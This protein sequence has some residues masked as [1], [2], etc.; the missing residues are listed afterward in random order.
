MSASYLRQGIDFLG[1]LSTQLQELQG[2]ATLVNELVQNAD[3]APGV[4][5]VCFDVRNDALEIS[6]DGSF[7]EQDFDRMRNIAGG[8]KRQETDTTGAFGIG[9]LAVYQVTDH[10]E[11]F[12][13][14]RHWVFHPEAA[15]DKRIVQEE[16]IADHG[17]TRFRLPWATDPQ[18]EVRRKLS[19]PPV[20]AK[21]IERL[22]EQ[23]DSLLPQAILFLRKVS[24]IQLCRNGVPVRVV[25][26]EVDG[27]QV[28]VQDGTKTR[29]WYRLEGDFYGRANELR[30]QYEGYI[31]PKRKATV[32]LA[33][34]QD[35]D[36]EQG[37]L[38]AYLPTQDSSNLS[39]HINADFF[40]TR[41]RKHIILGHNYHYQDE[42]NRA[43][44][45]AAAQKLATILPEL[46]KL[47]G[48]Q[49]FWRSL[50][51]AEES[52]RLAETGTID[53]VFGE[54]WN[55]MQP[56]LR[57]IPNVYTSDKRW[58]VPG[59]VF[60]LE[61]EEEHEAIP[62]LEASGLALVH[63]E[64]R[65]FHNLLMNKAVGV[66]RLTARDV[67]HA[68]C[69][70]GLCKAMDLSEAPSWIQS[71]HSR[72][73]LSREIGV[74]LRRRMSEAD[75]DQ[76]LVQI[77][78]CALG[79]GADGRLYPLADIRKASEE[80]KTLFQGATAQIVFL[81]PNNPE[82]LQELI[83]EFDPESALTALEQTPPETL[84][85]NWKSGQWRPAVLLGWF[86]QREASLSEKQK[87]RLAD[88]PIY[89]CGDCLRPLSGLWLPGGFS[90][91]LNLAEL[92]EVDSLPGLYDFLRK[93]GA[94]ELT[95]S[96][97]VKEHVPAVFD[98]HPRITDEARRALVFELAKHIGQIKDDEEARARLAECDFV[99]CD[100]GTFRKAPQVYLRNTTILDVL[101]ESVPT[102]TLPVDN[103]EAVRDLLLWLGVADSP[104][105]LDVLTRIQALVESA[106]VPDRREAIR[107]AFR[108]LGTVWK[109]RTE[110]WDQNVS[111]LKSLAWLPVENDTTSW[112]KPRDVFAVFQRYLCE[113]QARFLDI[114]YGDQQAASEFV[115]WLGVRETPDPAMVVAH[116]LAC[117]SSGAQVNRAVYRFLADSADDHV[118]ELLKG[119]PC[120]LLSTGSYAR[121][122]QVYWREHPFGTYRHQLQ[123]ELREYTKLFERLG[124][125]EGPQWQDA[126]QVLQ[127][128]SARFGPANTV[129][130]DESDK[131]AWEC[132]KLLDNALEQELTDLS[133][134]KNRLG[135]NKVVPDSRR[136]LM[137][138][139]RLFFDDR[140][141][142]KEKFPD[143]LQQHIVPLYQEAWRALE[144]AGVRPLS[145]VVRTDLIEC[146]NAR[147][148]E[149][150]I[151]LLAERK[152]LITRVVEP[153]Q[154]GQ[155][156]ATLA[157]NL[158][159][160]KFLRVDKLEV[161]YVFDGFGQPIPTSPES[162]RAHYEPP[163]NTLYFAEA[164]GVPWTPIAREL[165]YTLCRG[166]K[167]GHV[168]LA[169]KEILSAPSIDDASATLDELGFAPLKELGEKTLPPKPAVNLADAARVGETSTTPETPREASNA[170]FGEGA[171]TPTAPLAD[172][173]EAKN[174]SPTRKTE[175]PVATASKSKSRLRTYVAPE[176]AT[177]S[178]E[179]P[180]KTRKR[181]QVSK[182]G[183]MKVVEAERRAGRVPTEMPWTHRGY[184]IVSRNST[185][186]IERYIE[187]KALTGT[188]ADSPGV[189]LTKDE[190]EEAREKGGM[191]WLYVVERACGE[192]SCIIRIQDP[193]RK[194]GTFFYD[195]GWR[196]LAESAG[197]GDSH[198]ED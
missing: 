179:D 124:V 155:N 74:L 14:G 176:D 197:D 172:V 159:E 60:F 121:P 12:S 41:D 84:Q 130:D 99:E 114:P 98:K 110:L 156:G 154:V 40:P 85:A 93:L 77:R 55:L 111:E 185:E 31:E 82:D 5:M 88:L 50:G 63:P 92:V 13:S 24:R 181:Q 126:L 147:A 29:L 146:H 178:S 44:L 170:I 71:Q 145:K 140:P 182:A 115:K 163:S 6:N 39:F 36:S 139:E 102:A 61:S 16:G 133:T 3:D 51:R 134:L 68:L 174:G 188:W 168:A 57:E 95:F 153:I 30:S 76:A 122:H 118:L 25:Q 4:T 73:I 175:R 23:L 152:L 86:E 157:D 132:W 113:T 96:A 180:E 131:V 167:S 66:R 2:T 65:P 123:P 148:A 106:P 72:E 120:L 87:K 49:G 43:A 190:F 67:A 28:L 149:D 136:V 22:P 8:G 107:R 108:F 141:G 109:A 105:S 1:F 53:P 7:R 52:A 15:E 166:T 21:D 184:D 191:Y 11:L 187:V 47:L 79:V 54:F 64:L 59:D 143:D 18:S 83:S 42:W 58:L 33:F 151:E 144:A 9:F 26:R 164:D 196:L 198:G 112:A 48:H 171:P 37:L 80:T 127:E 169:I 128:I 177:A 101:G 69:R 19:L 173:S 97:Y 91:P 193:A 94:R 45:R 90:D 165:A 194:V 138:P 186:E 103:R 35:I 89:P 158:G 34:P 161:R 62:V 46:P 189:G 135:G 38:F 17:K 117:S 137:Q 10:P 150:L 27:N 129:L 32:T 100:D 160:I 75:K 125:R 119:K 142:L 183:V 116:L 78:Q 195:D 162:V 192:D 70:A 81:G 20:T 56:T 104:R